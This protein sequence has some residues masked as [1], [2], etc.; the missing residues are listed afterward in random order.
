M[1]VLPLSRETFMKYL[2]IL[3][4][5]ETRAETGQHVMLSMMKACRVGMKE[6]PVLI[7]RGRGFLYGMEVY[8]AD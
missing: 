8:L 5:Y 2:F 7:D 1:P 6:V 4:S 3:L